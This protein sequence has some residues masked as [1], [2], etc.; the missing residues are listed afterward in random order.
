MCICVCIHICVYMYI[1]TYI[2]SIYFSIC[3]VVT[4]VCS[5]I[6]WEGSSISSLGFTYPSLRIPMISD[7]WKHCI[8]LAPS[9]V[10]L[11]A[12]VD[13]WGG[14]PYQRS[15]TKG[16]WVCWDSEGQVFVV[17]PWD[18][19]VVGVAVFEHFSMFRRLQSFGL[20]LR[21]QAHKIPPIIGCNWLTGGP[22]IWVL[23]KLSFRSISP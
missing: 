17:L 5:H 7:S 1:Y 8:S 23:K 12:S 6:T 18:A 14:N 21:A 4:F 20:P 15:S 3:T 2:H 13:C 9:H 19:M 10:E 16:W 11:K 22:C